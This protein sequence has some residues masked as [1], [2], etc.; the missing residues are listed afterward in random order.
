LKPLQQQYRPLGWKGLRNLGQQVTQ[1]NMACW[2]TDPSLQALRTLAQQKPAQAALPSPP[3]A[4][5]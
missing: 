5:P 3:T 1:Q 2:Q 4:K